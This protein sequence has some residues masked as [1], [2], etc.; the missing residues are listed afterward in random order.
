MLKNVVISYKT[1]K[2]KVRIYKTI[3]GPTVEEA[4]EIELEIE[5]H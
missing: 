2:A 5:R 3:I 4:M 1:P